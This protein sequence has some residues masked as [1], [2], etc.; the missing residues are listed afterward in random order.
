MNIR[1]EYLII[2]ILIIMVIMWAIWFR[3]SNK[4][5]NKKYNPNNDKSKAGEE[6]RRRE[7]VVG[8]EPLFKVPSPN[9]E[10]LAEPIQ[11][12]VFPPTTPN[13]SGEPIID[14]PKTDGDGGKTDISS[15]KRTR[16]GLFRRKN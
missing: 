6:K 13:G 7:S 9:N 16:F 12:S 4:I 11:P 8:R 1:I 10:G 15:R 2:V 3:I 5:L 14:S